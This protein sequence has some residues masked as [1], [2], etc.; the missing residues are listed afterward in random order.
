MTEYWKKINGA[1]NLISSFGRVM[2]LHYD[3]IMNTSVKSS[4]YKSVILTS[5]CFQVHRLVAIAFLPNPF[6]LPIVNHI[7]GDKTN[8]TAFNLEWCTQ[9]DNIQKS[10]KV[11]KHGPLK[12]LAY[13]EKEF[14]INMLKNQNS[15]REISKITGRSRSAIRSVL[16]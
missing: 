10:N 5:G 6:N 16:I 11:G 15:I 7:D 3:R 9:K 2:S 14:I 1:N 13:N 4:G 8:N 12:R